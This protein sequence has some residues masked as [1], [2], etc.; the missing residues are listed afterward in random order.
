MWAGK[1]KISVPARKD[2]VIFDASRQY[3]RSVSVTYP[4]ST[5]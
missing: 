2:S 4:K 1:P 5:S 3:V